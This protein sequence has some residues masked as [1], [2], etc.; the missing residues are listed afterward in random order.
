MTVHDT[1]P[2]ENAVSD[3]QI[4][5]ILDDRSMDIDARIDSLETTLADTE[6]TV[7]DALVTLATAEDHV[8]LASNERYRSFERCCEAV[9]DRGYETA[10]ETILARSLTGSVEPTALEEQIQSH[11]EL[12]DEEIAERLATLEAAAQ[13]DV[14]VTDSTT[15][16][17]FDG[18]T[19]QNDDAAPVTNGESAMPS[20]GSTP[21]ESSDDYDDVPTEN[22]STPQSDDGPATVVSATDEKHMGSERP[23]EQTDPTEQ[24]A[25]SMPNYAQDLVDFEFVMESNEDFLPS[26]VDGSGMVLIEEDKYVG[27]IRIK[28]RSWSIH[29][30]AKKDE[31]INA[32]KSAFLATLDFPIQIVS[33]P[34]K[35][36]ISD[37]VSR[38]ED[39]AKES[40]SRSEDS[41]L[42]SLGRDLYP[43]WLERFI[44]DNDMKQRQFYVVVPITAD[45]LN[46][47]QSS[48]N[49]FLDTVGEK[50]PPLEPLADKFS[51]SDG[52][53]VSR[54]QC[55]RE[56]RSRMGRIESGLRR[57]DVG[58]ERLTDRDEVMSVIYH[59]YNN[60]QPMN[61]A[62]PTGPYSVAADRGGDQ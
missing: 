17:S 4:L 8:L 21:T 6:T 7:Q 38:L 42:V 52:Q 60:E 54:E 35:F 20:N 12:S 27:I 9:A 33:Y 32:Y 11:S 28:P 48:T 22:G 39:V 46:E 56:L 47:F 55:V 26:T 15:G 41:T 23:A 40:R 49:G 18:V 13:T 51:D 36:D 59:Y 50:V 45:Q 1:D 5:T 53:D 30:D 31:I 25:L 43:N 58:T 29:T 3:S 14:G 24:S 37:H 34:T 62:F 57:F 19:V 16:G 44:L 2:A 61:D 10:S